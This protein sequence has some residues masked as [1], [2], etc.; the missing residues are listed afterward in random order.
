MQLTKKCIHYCA[1]CPSSASVHRLML[2]T[3][4]GPLVHFTL[5]NTLSLARGRLG[6]QRLSGDSLLTPSQPF[7][8]PPHK[9]PGANQQDDAVLIVLIYKVLVKGIHVYGSQGCQ[10]SKL[11]IRKEKKRGSRQKRVHEH[12]YRRLE[13]R[14][15]STRNKRKTQKC[16]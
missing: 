12:K 3:S 4:V 13:R 16:P 14:G 8:H 7:A 2:Y 6:M 9:T 15:L 5:D 10:A 1:T 11:M